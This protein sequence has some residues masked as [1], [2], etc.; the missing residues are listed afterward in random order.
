MERKED[1]IGG[2]SP[3]YRD[4]HISKIQGWNEEM[5]TIK[6]WMD[7]PKNFLI[8]QGCPGSG[9]TYVAIALCLYLYELNT[10]NS[11]LDIE[12]VNVRS[13]FNY[14]K[15]R[16]SEGKD[17]IWPKECLMK[18]KWLVLDDL[19]AAR[20]TEWQQE[21]VLDIIDE[22]YNNMMPTIITTNFSFE[23]IG[24]IFGPRVQSRLQ[25][26]ENCVV[27]KWNVDLRRQGF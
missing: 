7:D 25:A 26:S 16:F 21:T 8:L 2:L 10:Q 4:A 1:F 9:K 13:F 12:F 18:T 3:R 24:K 23:D 27:E 11:Y 22:R 15:K 5:P 20:N 6:E 14:L 17:D 19:G